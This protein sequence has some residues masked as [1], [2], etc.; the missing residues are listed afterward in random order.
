MKT[1]KFLFTVSTFLIIHGAADAAEQTNCYSLTI[2]ESALREANPD[3]RQETWCY[4]T[5]EKGTFIYNADQE[6]V[7]PEL[8]FLVDEKGVI[9][10][11]SLAFDKITVHRVKAEDFNP[12]SVPFAEP[13]H[14]PVL[15]M[16]ESL[17]ASAAV[18]RDF[19]IAHRN[20]RVADFKVG[21]INAYAS[22]ASQPWRG[23]WFPYSSMRMRGPMG[24]YDRFV[25]ARTGHNPGALSWENSV[26]GYRGVNWEGHCNGWAAASILRSEPASSRTAEGVT[27]EV[28]DLKGI[29]TELDYCASAA[30]FGSRNNGSGDPSD[31]YPAVFHKALLYY[32]GSLHKPIVMDRMSSAP[33]D[34]NVIS[35]YSMDM[36]K[37]GANTYSVTATLTMHAYDKS[38]SNATGPA[39]SYTKVYK[40]V[41]RTDANGN[42]VG[43]YW[44]SGNPDFLWAPLSPSKCP[45]GNPRLESTWVDAIRNS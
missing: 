10:H 29:L 45:N 44:Q 34:N 39:P 22:A 1:L 13:R 17:A 26:H 24:K 5:S 12:L 27:F 16:D 11:G 20:D 9:T 42:P 14:L 28:A 32:I 4:Q 23:Y 15:Q 25:T 6:Y 43:G 35:A 19:F 2:T 33:V 7:K 8:A 36:R 37:T 31:V 40:Y 41:L 38:F 18:V 30:F 3:P 21:E